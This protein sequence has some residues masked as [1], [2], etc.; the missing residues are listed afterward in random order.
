MTLFGDLRRALLV[1]LP[2]RFGTT[3]LDHHDRD[4]AGVGPPTRDDELERRLVTLLVRRVRDPLSVVVRQPHRAD[5]A[6]ERDARDRQ[7]RRRA[8]D[9]RDV[10]RVLEVGAEDRRDDLHLVAEPFGERRPQRPVG[11]PAGEDRLLARTTLTAEE[12]AR[13]LA[14]GVHP[15]L[16]VDRQREE[17]DALPWLVGDDRG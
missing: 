7:R 10:V 3:G 6:V 12:R 5:R 15:L 1:Q 11:E 17:V 14:R 8:V 13:D 2:R 4:L 9:R 16:D